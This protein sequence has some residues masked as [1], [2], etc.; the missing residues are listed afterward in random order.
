[1]NLL[2]STIYGYS[3]KVH[4]R[5]QCNEYAKKSHDCT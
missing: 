2:T 5:V 1:M 4:G 3:E